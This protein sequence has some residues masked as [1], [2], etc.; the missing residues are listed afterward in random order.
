MSGVAERL[1]AAGMSPAEAARKEAL[2]ARAAPEFPGSEWACF[3]PG[4]VELLGKHT[5][6]AGGRSLLCATERGI[7]FLGR[8]RDDP[9]LHLTDVAQGS[10]IALSLRSHRQPP[11]GSWVIYPV[12]VA[13]RL[14]RDFGITRGIDLAFASDLPLAAGL[15]SST[16]LC[17]GVYSALAFANRLEE[18]PAYRS[19]I[20]NRFA[21]ADYLGCVENGRPF[22]PFP[23]DVGAGILGGSQDQTAIL[24]AQPGELLQCSFIPARPERRLPFPAGHTL[25]IAASGVLAEKHHATRDAYNAAANAVGEIV[26]RWQHATGRGDQTLAAALTSSPAARQRLEE[27]V[28]GEP[29]LAARLEQFVTESERLVP[30]AGDAVLAGDLDAFGTVVDRS[31]AGADRGLRNQIPETNHLQ[32]SARW[33]GAVAASAFGAGFGGSVWAM[34]LAERAEGFLRDWS[35]DYLQAFPPHAGRAEFFTTAAGPPLLSIGN[36]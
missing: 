30:A 19:A 15:S 6:Y 8:A 31:H 27:L 22:G 35:A 4:R 26:R 17:L 33:L 25:V 5:D 12:T 14:A 11:A 2:F 32:R 34:V 16:A 36:P 1:V 9:E 28:A 29:V 7:C 24:G 20:A 18:H 23:G 13:R 10:R 3:V 21:L